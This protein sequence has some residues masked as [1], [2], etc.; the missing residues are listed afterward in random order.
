M[1]YSAL[2]VIILVILIGCLFYFQSKKLSE[3]IENTH[4]KIKEKVKE[5]IKE[6]E[7]EIKK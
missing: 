5:A 4:K 1:N 3:K 2:I 7:E 6:I